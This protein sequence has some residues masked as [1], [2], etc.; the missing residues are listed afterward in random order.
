MFFYFFLLPFWISI[1]LTCHLLFLSIYCLLFLSLLPFF[2]LFIYLSFN[3][4]FPFIFLIVIPFIIYFLIFDSFYLI[5]I[6]LYFELLF[7]SFPSSFSF[8]SCVHR[9]FP[10][11]PFY[12]V[13]LPVCSLFICFASILPQ[14]VS[15]FIR[16]I[17][18]YFIHYFWG[19]ILILLFYLS[20]VYFLKY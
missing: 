8:F 9:S 15:L 14:F 1:C 2:N 10:Y 7:L 13:L 19:I 6:I 12:Y 11:F 17:F 18:T 5:S 16:C 3:Y 4:L 20:L